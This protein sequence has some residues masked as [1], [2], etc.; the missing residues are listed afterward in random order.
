[1]ITGGKVGKILKIIDGAL[2]GKAYVHELRDPFQVLISTI[3]SA[4]T[5]D[6]V[7]KEVSES[8]F[9]KIKD[10]RDLAEMKISEIERIIK[11]TGFFHTKAKHLKET[12]KKIV[13]IGGVPDSIE[14]LVKLPGVGRKTANLVLAVA[15]DKP[16][17][18][19]DT[20]VHRISNRWGLVATKTPFETEMSL[21]GKVDQK[22]WKEMNRIMVPFGKFICKPIRPLCG[23]CPINV[24]CPKIGVAN[25]A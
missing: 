21:R 4:R 11:K 10:P 12:S 18:C 5:K 14:E 20:H 7:T 8:L 15:F 23:R 19:V 25:Q 13:E 1:V 17:L 3:L 24:E 9:K 6:E 2:S 16:G 22:H